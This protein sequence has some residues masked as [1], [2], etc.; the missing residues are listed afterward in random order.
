MSCSAAGLRLGRNAPRT[1]APS[2]FHECSSSRW[3]AWTCNYLPSWV[4]G[5]EM[6]T[7][8]RQNMQCLLFRPK[9]KRVICGRAAD[10]RPTMESAMSVYEIHRSAK[11]CMQ[12]V[13]I[14]SKELQMKAWEQSLTAYS[15]VGLSTHLHVWLGPMRYVAVPSI[16]FA[17]CVWGV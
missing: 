16:T 14:A 15:K 2:L 5:R 17:D 11:L 6:A 13:L 10:R 12:S 1:A 4:G 3:L 7:S 8:Q 9:M